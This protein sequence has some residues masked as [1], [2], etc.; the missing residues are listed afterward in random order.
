[1]LPRHAIFLQYT[2]HQSGKSVH[3]VI[4]ACKHERRRK[5]PHDGLLAVLEV[6]LELVPVLK[7]DLLEG[8]HHG[9]GALCLLVGLLRLEFED[10]AGLQEGGT[11]G[12]EEKNR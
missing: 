5:L 2:Y 10:L 12:G 7:V 6:V 3:I 4:P 1:M 8:T 11:L 9:E